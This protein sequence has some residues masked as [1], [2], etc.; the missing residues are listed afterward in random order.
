MPETYGPNIMT[1]TVLPLTVL[2][3]PS[4]NA[5]KNRV[6]LVDTCSEKRELRSDAMRK[7]GMDVDCAS[8]INEARS[9]WRPDV[10][11]LILMNVENEIEQRD[12]FC[13][14]MRAATPPQQLAFLVGKPKYLAG[15]PNADTV[16]LHEPQIDVALEE[17]KPT[18]APTEISD[19]LFRWGIMAASR[20][21]SQVRSVAV[22]HTTA[23]RNRPAPPRDHDVRPPRRGDVS[24]L[25]IG[26]GEEGLL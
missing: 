24:K 14:D 20:R 18:A 1:T 5:K 10:Y 13:D 8:D 23:K 21:I 16:L 3:P 11:D 2:I 26:L 6:L 17:Q 22:A 9:W 7:L 15:L 12:K 4:R 25:A 19:S